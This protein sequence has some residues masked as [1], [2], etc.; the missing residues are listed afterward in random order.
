[1]HNWRFSP[2]RHFPAFRFASA[3]LICINAIHE[4]LYCDWLTAN[5]S[6]AVGISTVALQLFLN[7]LTMNMQVSLFWL[8][9]INPLICLIPSL[10]S[11]KLLT[12]SRDSCLVVSLLPTRAGHSCGLY[13]KIKFKKS[14]T[15][16]KEPKTDKGEKP[17]TLVVF[18]PDMY[19]HLVTIYSSIPSSISQ[20]HLA[21][22]ING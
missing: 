5:I 16:R 4:S 9:T 20:I 11:F 21:L 1:M 6:Q 13:L 22:T 18:L 7:N 15:Q 14:K 2:V 3:S 19:L 10:K 8:D 17:L 12:T